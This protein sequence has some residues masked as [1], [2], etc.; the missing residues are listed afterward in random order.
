[1]LEKEEN[2]EKELCI[3]SLKYDSH[4]FFLKNLQYIIIFNFK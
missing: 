2:E 4:L 3:L 1:M